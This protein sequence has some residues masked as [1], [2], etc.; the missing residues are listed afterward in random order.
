M[1]PAFNNWEARIV[2]L[3][4]LLLFSLQKVY[5]FSD[6]DYFIAYGNLEKLDLSTMNVKKIGFFD[7]TSKYLAVAPNGLVWSRL[8]LKSIGGMNVDSGEVAAKI[9]LPYRPYRITILGNGLAIVSHQIL[10]KDGIPLSIVDTKKKIYVKTIF[11]LNGLVTDMVADDSVFISTFKLKPPRGLSVYRMDAN[12]GKLVKILQS[13]ITDSHYGISLK[14]NLLF[15]SLL[16]GIG[17]KR[18]S[19]I[20]VLNRKTGEEVKKIEGEGLNGVSRIIG[21]P[22]FTNDFGCFECVDRNGRNGIAILSLKKLI[23]TNV[24]PLKGNIYR[25]L[26]VSK[27]LIAY[28]NIQPYL[29]KGKLAICFFDIEAGKEVKRVNILP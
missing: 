8:T 1:F 27:N 5:L 6:T 16:P 24:L 3:F 18:K 21:K 10:V 13:N 7:I 23:V 28:M 2:V 19:E 14:G 15:V 17:S 29:E 25:I 11:G 20:I 4:P 26:S 22:V 9:N 12:N